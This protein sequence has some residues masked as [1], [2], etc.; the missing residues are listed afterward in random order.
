MG[1]S[2]LHKPPIRTL[3]RS[4]KKLLHGSTRLRELSTSLT[5]RRRRES[6]RAKQRGKLFGSTSQ[7]VEVQ[8]VVLPDRYG[9]GTRTLL[10][11]RANACR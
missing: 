7:F 3:L 1:R 9:T 8:T 10:K 6:H 4:R 11:N 2:Q 5:T